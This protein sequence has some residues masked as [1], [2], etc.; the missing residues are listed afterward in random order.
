MPAD[1]KQ[2]MSVESSPFCSRTEREDGVQIGGADVP[3]DERTTAIGPVQS[4]QHAM[5]RGSAP[6]DARL[7]K[8]IA[9][10]GESGV[11]VHG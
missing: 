2:R 9:I 11:R 3:V 4:V 5:E 8:G 1:V 10:S 7:R 6:I